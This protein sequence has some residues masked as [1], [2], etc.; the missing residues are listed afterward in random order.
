MRERRFGERASAA[1]RLRR[2]RPRP[3]AAPLEPAQPQPVAARPLRPKG[4]P[5]YILPNLFTAASL[6]LALFSLV[7]VSEGEFM[8]AAWLIIGSAVCD[9]IDGPV[10]RLTRTSSNFGLQFD[11]LAD[12]VAFGVAPAFLMF[13]HLGLLDKDMLP[14]YAPRL[15]LGA[16]ALY[17]ICA[18]IRLARFNIQAATTEKNHF[19]GLPSPGAAG[20][21]VSAFLFVEWL[22]GYMS[23]IDSLKGMLD[24]KGL[25]V[26]MHRSTLLLMVALALL[27]VSEV[28]FSKLK[29]ILKV[30]NKQFQSLVILLGGACVLI[31]FADFMPVI[32]FAGFAVYIL[33]SVVNYLRQPKLTLP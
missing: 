17:V 15:A 22:T 20:A 13:K 18:A 33:V 3:E 25:T 5:I 23:G 8:F 28:P 2:V 24:T 31:T 1:A 7:K 12:I 9:A 6:F 16:C 30:A 19:T 11:S 27:M 10:A 4:S 29:H 32:L 21:V 26:N 14:A